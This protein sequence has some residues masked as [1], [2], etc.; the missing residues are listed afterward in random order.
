MTVN[1]TVGLTPR[2]F[3]V[4]PG[5]NYQLFVK[6]YGY[7]TNISPPFTVTPESFQTFSFSLKKQTSQ[8]GA[9]HIGSNPP[10]ANLT[11]L[12]IK[13]D[14]TGQIFGNTPVSLESLPPG[15]YNYTLTMNGYK[16]AKGSTEILS[17]NVTE[18][19]VPMIPI[20][21]SAL[22]TFKSDPTNAKIVLIGGTTQ[23]ANQ[24]LAFQVK[25]IIANFNGTPEDAVNITQNLLQ[26]QQSLPGRAICGLIGSTPTTMRLNQ[27]YYI[28]RYYLDGYW[29]ENGVAD[30]NV[31]VGHDMDVSSKMIPNQQFVQVYFESNVDDFNESE[32][33]DTTE[34]NSEKVRGPHDDKLLGAVVSINGTVIGKTPGW[35][36]LPSNQFVNVTFDKLPM[37]AP[38][39]ITVD[40]TLF[41]GR[42]SKWGKIIHLNLMDYYITTIDDEHSSI[43]PSGV[44][45]VAAGQTQKFDLTGESPAWLVGNLTV[46]RDG[47]NPVVYTY[48]QSTA[49]YNLT[50]IL[51]NATLNLTSVKKRVAVNATAGKGGSVNNGGITYYDYGTESATYNFVADPGYQP[52]VLWE[53]GDEKHYYTVQFSSTEMVQNHTLKCF[54]R[55]DNV[56]ITPNSS[57]GGK[58][59][60]EGKE[61]V[62]YWIAYDEC[63]HE[64]EIVADPGYKCTYYKF[65]PTD[66]KSLSS[67]SE[68]TIIPSQCGVKE[69]LTLN[70][71]FEPLNYTV[72]SHATAGGFDISGPY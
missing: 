18:I 11:L 62:P 14:L 35:V 43:S 45:E 36:S 37:F 50:H 19:Y 2:E 52:L 41:E 29:M 68:K 16:T 13:D 72:N 12:R 53:D 71:Y 54:F 22:I 32:A 33:E 59:L 31:S 44:I 34:F 30:F 20:P 47:H 6:K 46:H 61:A 27:G 28:Y 49:V 5:N 65:T 4:D 9:I 57:K 40:T 51:Q 42:P 66:V 15:M 55:P 23:G 3:F 70:V 1:D 26:S 39:T 56:L 69:N 60:D 24:S 7:I 63:T 38:K 67:E 64:H 17:G 58:I 25:D 48:N 10:G 8:Y 21:D